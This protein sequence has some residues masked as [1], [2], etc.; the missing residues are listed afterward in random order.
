MAP[1]CC[2]WE[3]VKVREDSLTERIGRQRNFWQRATRA[4]L[5]YGGAR[6]Y[7]LERAYLFFCFLGF[8]DCFAFFFD[9]FFAGAGFAAGAASYRPIMLP[10][11]SWNTANDPIPG[12]ISCLAMISVPPAACIL[13]ANSAI[14]FR[15]P[16]VA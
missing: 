10:S 5:I 4:A 13:P 16:Y 12:P 6:A 1:P 9:A 3:I 2:G 7:E 15:P 11:V 14:P 8:F